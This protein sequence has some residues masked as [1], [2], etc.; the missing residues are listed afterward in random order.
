MR[1]VKFRTEDK[2]SI[3]KV[4]ASLRKTL[5]PGDIILSGPSSNTIFTR[6][7]HLT[8]ILTKRI[9][10]GI[11]H[12]C[13]YLGDDKILD[14]DY[15]II[16]SGTHVEETT[17][18]QFVEDK[19]GFFGGVMIYVVTPKH[20]SRIQRRLAV[21]ESRERFLTENKRLTHTL[22]GSV[23]VG[24]RY[25]F[26]RRSKYVEDLTFRKD[27]TCGHM[28]AYILKKSNVDIGKRA[29]YTFVPPMFAYSKYF[30]I[31]KKIVLK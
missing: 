19:L 15:K 14:I 25:V 10:R 9:M 20:Y 12:S 31:E 16:R 3:D 30:R 27:W 5:R 6:Y 13:M 21:A 22:W 8:L 26:F 23:V 11:T 2:D 18:K 4:V 7:I 29:S 24:W 1:T 17:L 28:V